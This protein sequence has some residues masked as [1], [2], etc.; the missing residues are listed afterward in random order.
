MLDEQDSDDDDEATYVKGCLHTPS[1]QTTTN[2]IIEVSMQSSHD[3]NAN[4]VNIGQN[5]T[6]LI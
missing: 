1:M 5:S 4:A 2:Q 6:F 3:E